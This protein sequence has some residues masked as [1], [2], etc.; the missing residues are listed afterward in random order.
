MLFN[1]VVSVKDDRGRLH[2]VF[3]CKFLPDCGGHER[4]GRILLYFWYPLLGPR[5][6]VFSGQGNALARASSRLLAPMMPMAESPSQASPGQLRPSKASS[7]YHQVSPGQ[8]R[9]YHQLS[10]G[11][12][13]PAQ[14]SSGGPVGACMGMGACWRRVGALWGAYLEPRGGQCRKSRGIFG[15]LWGKYRPVGAKTGPVWAHTGSHGV[16]RPPKHV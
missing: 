7:G 5:I 12:P 3:T 10:P 14:A 8:P 15:L 16:P 11:Q 9:R 6:R 1:F 4:G 13:R 2:K